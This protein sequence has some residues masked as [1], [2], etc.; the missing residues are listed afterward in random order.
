V[1]LQNGLKKTDI[2][3]KIIAELPY[4]MFAHGN[5]K[6]IFHVDHH[7]NFRYRCFIPIGNLKVHELMYIIGFY[8]HNHFEYE[9]YTELR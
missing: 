5:D 2:R 3:Y 8:L 6:W 1:H 4:N 7:N 9:E